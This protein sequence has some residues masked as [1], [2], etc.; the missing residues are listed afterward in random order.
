MKKYLAILLALVMVLSL[1]ACAKTA[2]E[3]PAPSTDAA[4][5]TENTTTEETKTEETETAARAG[6]VNGDGK[7][8]VGYISKNIVDVFHNTINTAATEKLDSFVS[9]GIIDE[10]TGV[11]D[12]ET[13]PNKQIDLA[14]NCISMGCDYVIILP[15]ESGASDPAVTSMTD[16]GIQVIV[17]NSKTDSTDSLALTY[18]GSD[19]VYAGELMGNYVMEKVPEGGVYVHCQGVIGNSAQ[20]QRGEGILNVLSDAWTCAADVPCDWGADKAVNAATDYMAQYGDDLKAIICD[21]DDMSSAA[22]QA[23]NDAGR[24]DI[25]CIGVDGNP[26]PLS[27][28][29]AGTLGATVL[30]DGAG[31][32]E[33][34]IECIRLAIEG[35]T[36]EK[37]YVV[38][39]VLVTA[40]NVDE[41]YSG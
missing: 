40:D 14:T 38:P 30:Q 36:I 29:K 6:D 8:I 39:F 1:A 20:I 17:V 27:M 10:W 25:V 4:A 18:V 22:Q 5:S 28:V 24:S 15:A 37:N 41:Y 31:Q 13:D 23:C 21:N 16:A 33:Q 19:D 12:G 7:I 3:E 35:K 32:V 2:T 11:L 34:G 26:G 9:E